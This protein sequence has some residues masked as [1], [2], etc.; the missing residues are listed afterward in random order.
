MS[1]FTPRFQSTSSR[2]QRRD[3]DVKLRV[4]PDAYA[5]E[6]ADSVYSRRH[7]DTQKIKNLSFWENTDSDAIDEDEW[8]ERQ[9]ATPFILVMVILVVASTLLWFMF[10]WASGENTSTPPI[11]PADT[12]PFKVRPNNPGGMMIPHQDKL[13]YGRLSQDASQPIE[14]LLPP[15][16]QPM[17]HHPMATPPYQPPYPQGQGYA[18]ANPPPPS[19]YAPN[20][21]IQGAQPS[22]ASHYAPPPQPYPPFQAQPTYP[23]QPPVQGQL[24]YSAPQAQSPY[25]PPAAPMPPAILP[26][27][28]EASPQP[29]SP[30]AESPQTSAVEEIKPASD[31]DDADDVITQEGQKELDQLIAREAEKPLKQ[32][33][34]KNAGKFSKS[35]TINLGKHKV[36]IA[37]LPSRVMAENEMKRLRDHHGSFFDNKPWNIQKINLGAERGITHRLVVGS[38]PNH[39]AATKFCKRLRAE[40]I[41]CLVIAPANE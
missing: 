28:P 1:Q 33:A 9:S 14:R 29:I 13:V 4:S 26:T 30:S 6:A 18:P 12:T 20:P 27:M 39:N 5:Q 34:K 8:T 7:H 22:A 36:Q 15:P 2:P 3:A 10:Q 19:G 31:E 41:G 40:K 16:E 24:P 37:S 25:G 23:Q 21:T 11:I 17:A 32:P 38:F 35:T